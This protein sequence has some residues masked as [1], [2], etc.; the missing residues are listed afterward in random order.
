ME[1]Y[2]KNPTPN[3]S[4]PRGLIGLWKMTT[5][6][7]QETPVYTRGKT[8]TCEWGNPFTKLGGDPVVPQVRRRRE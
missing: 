2:S 4:R 7:T 3:G 6:T 5:L 1:F 8:S